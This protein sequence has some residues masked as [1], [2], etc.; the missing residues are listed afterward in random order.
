MCAIYEHMAALPMANDQPN[1][2]PDP[3]PQTSQTED[4]KEQI[5]QEIK[6]ELRDE[7]ASAPKP[8]PVDS[9]VVLTKEKKK[10]SNWL[11]KLFEPKHDFY[12]LLSEQSQTTLSGMLALQSY[13]TTG[14]LENKQKV[15][16]F[17]SAADEQKLS[18]E[19][20]LNDSFVTP[21]DREDIYDIAVFLDEI[22][23]A[24]KNTVREM[25]AMQMHPSDPAFIEMA[26]IL[27]EGTRCINSSFHQLNRNHQ[28]AYEFARLARKSENRLSKTYRMAMSE[29]FAQDDVKLIFKTTEIYRSL[30]NAAEKI[31]TLGEKLL[32]VIVKMS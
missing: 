6:Q 9:T 28:E 19:K 27:V 1:N 15:R 11:S 2:E 5:K 18:L 26:E 23:N 29:L 12:A 10:Q 20:K 13:L 17:E 3:V 14:S 24:A 25:D 31:N 7:L 4:L 8:H 21:F 16:D 22:I 32:H 30:L